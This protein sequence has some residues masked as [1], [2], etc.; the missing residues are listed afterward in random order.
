MKHDVET[1]G[2]GDDEKGIPDEEQE[3]GLKHFVEHRDV[4]IVPG[5]INIVPGDINIVPGDINIVPGD[6]NIV[7]G[8]VNI[9]P[10]DIWCLEPLRCI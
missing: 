8:D 1:Q 5:D 9:V 2:E 3:K 4:N 10:G 6:I 7:S